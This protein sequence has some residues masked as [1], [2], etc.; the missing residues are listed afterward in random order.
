MLTVWVAG[1]LRVGGVVSCTVIWKL[2][3]PVFPDESVAVQLTVVVPSGKL[4]PLEG[5]QDGVPADE[6]TLKVTVA[7]VTPFTDDESPGVVTIGASGPDDHVE[8]SR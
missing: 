8:R 3:E 2:P 1:R 4:E 7:L 6:V 5:T